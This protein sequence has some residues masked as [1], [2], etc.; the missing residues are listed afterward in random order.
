LTPLS[1]LS[2]KRSQTSQLKNAQIISPIRVIA[3]N[4]E[5]AL[6]A[7]AELQTVSYRFAAKLAELE[8]QFEAKASELRVAYLEEVAAIQAA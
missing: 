6:A 3:A 5:I 7:C 2:L 8:R 4:H 1:K